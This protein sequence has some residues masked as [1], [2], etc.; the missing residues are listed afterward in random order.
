MKAFINNINEDEMLRQ[1]SAG[2]QFAFGLVFQLY[3]QKLAHF[4]FYYLN[5]R[6]ATKDVVQDVFAI[7]W[8]DRE[9]FADVSN[10]SSWLFTVTKN[11]CLKKV[12]HLK[13]KQKH[14]D[15][16]KYRQLQVVHSSLTALDTSPVL[17]SEINTIVS[18]TLEK[19]S[20]VARQVFELSRFENRKN[21]EIAEELNISQKTVEAHITAALKI[22]RKALKNYLPLVLFLFGL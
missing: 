15:N 6:E 10:L 17:F 22:F 8:E 13:V 16:L 20:P 4:A 2:D 5:D 9:K 3:S 11:Q 1:L 7:I 14:R 19:L 21:R 18:Q 12:E